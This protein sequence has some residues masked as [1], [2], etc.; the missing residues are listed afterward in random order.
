MNQRGGGGLNI[1][2]EIDQTCAEPEIILH[3]SKITEQLEKLMESIRILTGDN[4]QTLI[5]FKAGEA[6]LLQLQ[7]VSSIFTESGKVY[8]RTGPDSYILKSRLYELEEK[9]AGTQFL[10]VSNSEIVNFKK[11]KSLDLSRTGTIML[12]FKTGE[13]TFVS[14]RYVDKIK[15]YFQL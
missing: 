10:R 13:T 7:D 3:A 5:G 8:A 15:Q 6:F 9:L 11:V 2:V 4:L 1:K 14:R 12:K